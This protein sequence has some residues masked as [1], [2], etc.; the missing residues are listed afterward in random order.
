MLKLKD[1]NPRKYVTT[2]EI[3][4]NLLRLFNK[5]A[6]IENAYGQA[7]T[8]TSG[9]RDQAKQQALI[10]S[11]KSKASKSLHL[12]GEA[13]DIYD[14]YGELYAWCTA[15]IDKLEET[16]LWREDRLDTPSW[17]HVQTRPPKSGRRTF[18]A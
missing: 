2:P 7:L 16:G 4:F 17:L 11:G 8:V 3:N 9:L 1:L 13:C 15:N 5:I 6:Q 12:S 18:R 14:P 10:E